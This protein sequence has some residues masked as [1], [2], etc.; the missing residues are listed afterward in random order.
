MVWR[1]GKQLRRGEYIVKKKL[2]EGGFGVTYQAW[3]Q[4]LQHFV[5]I[6]TPNKTL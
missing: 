6:K 1:A 3:H 4:H 5:V 2:G